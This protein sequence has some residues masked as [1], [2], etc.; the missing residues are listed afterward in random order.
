VLQA[1]LGGQL[2]DLDSWLTKHRLG[3]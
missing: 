1:G 2:S 3:V